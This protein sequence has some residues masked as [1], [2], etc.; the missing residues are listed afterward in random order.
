[1]KSTVFSALAG[2]LFLATSSLA[3]AG[4]VW[5]ASSCATSTTTWQVA[6]CTSTG[7]QKYSATLTGWSATSSGNFTA[8][9][10]Y[11][12]AEGLGVLTYGE[13]A[14]PQHAIDNNGSTD[15]ILMSFGSSFALK[16]LSS[17]WIYGDADVSIMRYTGTT[18]PVLGSSKVS[19][20]MSA[21]GWE[22]VGHY[23]I[24]N[25]STPLNF[26]AANKTASWW[27][28]S[29]YNSSY[30]GAT[31]A[32]LNNSNDYFKLKSFSGELISNQVPE[33]GSWSLLGVAMLG[34]AA[35][36]RKTRGH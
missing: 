6:N 20:L 28:V 3:I 12:Y 14:S 32:N 8:A 34:F 18:A 36:R 27:L 7:T 15:A 1:M 29:A 16:Q 2:V 17:G 25:T 33:P 21:P 26:N 30:G 11:G 19:T 35:V 5:N 22:L 13:N 23:N 4:P 24:A 9:A 31:A 10:I